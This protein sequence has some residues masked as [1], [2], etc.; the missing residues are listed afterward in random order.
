MPKKK[1][2]KSKHPRRLSF[3]RCG[4]VNE[5]KKRVLRRLS[6]RSRPFPLS[7]PCYS[8]P[9]P[10]FLAAILPLQPLLSFSNRPMNHPTK[11]NL[12]LL[13]LLLLHRNPPFFLLQS[14]QSFLKIPF[15][16]PLLSPSTTSTTTSL[17][18]ASPLRRSPSFSA[19][20]RARFPSSPP[21][22]SSIMTTIPAIPSLLTTNAT[23]ETVEST[24]ICEPASRRPGIP[25]IMRRCGT[26]RCDWTACFPRITC[27]RTTRS[28]DSTRFTAARG[29]WCRCCLRECTAIRASVR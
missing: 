7:S 19:T 2:K 21:P 3:T 17:P 23:R 18:E 28:C 27:L 6:V 13:L 25:A 15:L 5:A 4:Q 10:P 20:P 29:V 16:P 24:P 14:L 1:K 12:L 22:K 11:S 8:P 26:K 9:N